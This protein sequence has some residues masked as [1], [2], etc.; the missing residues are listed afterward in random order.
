LSDIDFEANIKDG[1]AVDWPI[2]YKDIAP[3]YDYVEKFIGISGERLGLPQLPDG[4]FLPPMEMNCLEKD[5]KKRVE[6]NFKGRNITMGRVAN[7]SVPHNGR[8]SCQNRNLCSRGCPYGAYFSTQSS[9]L[10]AAVATGNLTLRPHSI[11]NSVIYDDSKGK[12]TG[13][14]VIDSQ[15]NEMIEYFSKIVFLNASAIGSTFVMLN[16]S[17]DRFPNGL[18]N[19]SEQLGKNLMD[20]HFR[21][22]ASGESDDFQ[23]QY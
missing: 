5:V 21:A 18:G 15:T 14:R 10:P 20:H 19:S 3:W 17:S 7:L 12:A 4:Q 23:D 1:I 11:V 6:T 9:T 2:R 22:G 13:V 8:G 16:S